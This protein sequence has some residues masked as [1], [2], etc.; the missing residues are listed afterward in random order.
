MPVPPLALAV[1]LAVT[2]TQWHSGT[3]PQWPLAALATGSP[4]AHCA[5]SGTLPVAG[6]TVPGVPGQ[7]LLG[8]YYCRR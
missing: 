8:R 4:L 7:F 2:G 6:P 3:V 1:A 5:S